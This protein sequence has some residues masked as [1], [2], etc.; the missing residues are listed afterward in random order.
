VRPNHSFRVWSAVTYQELKGI[1][2]VPVAQVPGLARAFV[3]DAIILFG[4]AYDTCVLSRVEKRFAVARSIVETPFQKRHKLRAHFLLAGFSAHYR[5]VSIMRRLG[6]PWC[7]AA[8]TLPRFPSSLAIDPIEIV[9]HRRNGRAQAVDVQ[10][11]EFDPIRIPTMFVLASEPLNKF[12]HLLVAPHP[13][14][15]PVE[16]FLCCGTRRMMANV[17]INARRVRPVG[18]D[19]DHVEPMILD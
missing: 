10:A 11:A 9:Q 15:K 2:H 6:L 17:T 7:Q 13:T 1:E 12:Q 19:G 3:H 16:R 8:I 4:R 14:W 5:M 18:L